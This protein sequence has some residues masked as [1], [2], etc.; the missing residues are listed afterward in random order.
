MIRTAAVLATAGLV[1]GC[2]SLFL[3]EEP[4]STPEAVFDAFWWEFDKYYAFF[5][6]KD[7]DWNSV[8]TAHRPDVSSTTPDAALFSTLVDMVEPF[9]DGHITLYSEFRE[10]SYD[11]WRTRSP[12]NYFPE[13]VHRRLDGGGFTLTPGRIRAG[14]IGSR[15]GYVAIENFEGKGFGEAMDRALEELP[16]AEALIVDVRFNGG[17]SDL[18]SDAVLSRFADQKRVYAYVRYRNGPQHDDFTAPRPLT[19]EPGGRVRFPGPVAVL[20]NRGTFSTAEGFVLAM[21]VLPNT[22]V[23]GDTTGGGSGNP[24][25]RELPNGWSVGLSRWRVESA[26]GVPFEDI[27]IAPDLPI[28]I[29]DEDRARGVDTILEAAVSLLID[30]LGA[31]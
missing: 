20:T 4:V 18:N 22:T 28:W 1:S 24:Y 9:R 5:G 25:W 6:D 8:Y 3:P 13:A 31:G 17:G 27:G 23:V 2:V 11:G 16:A 14:M 19:L 21:R 29:T 30:R 10:W 7:V 26:D 12:S 15:I